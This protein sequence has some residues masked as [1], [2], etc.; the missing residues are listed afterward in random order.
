MKSG[1]Q[2]RK[3]PAQNWLSDL[4]VR[5]IWKNILT[6]ITSY[7]LK[8]R[9]VLIMEDMNGMIVPLY[10]ELKMYAPSVTFAIL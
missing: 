6:I 9:M 8:T 7:V 4:L 2:I 1:R 3:E 5:E 10:R